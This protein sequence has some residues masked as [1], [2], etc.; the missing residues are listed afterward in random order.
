M[1]KRHARIYPLNLGIRRCRR[2]TRNQ[3]KGETAN[4]PLMNLD[5]CS[6]VERSQP[7]HSKSG[8]ALKY[9]AKDLNLC[10]SSRREEVL[11]VFSSRTT[12]EGGLN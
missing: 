8:V 6:W 4:V 5:A 2:V 11:T 1:S 3:G 7:D 10:S 12:F 9:S